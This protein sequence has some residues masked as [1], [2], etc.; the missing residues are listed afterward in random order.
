MLIGKITMNT[1]PRQEVVGYFHG[2]YYTMY[3]PR[4]N[5]K[6]VNYL[7]NDFGSFPAELL[8]RSE[9]NLTK[10]LTV[11]FAEIANRHGG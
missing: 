2:Y 1:M 9:E 6:I 7:K 8:K 10:L 3:D 4:N 5:L 11:D